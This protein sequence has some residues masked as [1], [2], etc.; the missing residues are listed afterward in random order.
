M[1]GVRPSLA[2]N[3]NLYSSSPDNAIRVV[4]SG[5]Q[6]PAKGELGYM[7]AFRY[8]LNDEQIAALL[9]Y[10]RQDFAKQKPWPDVQQR[11]A[12]LRAETAPSPQPSPTGRGS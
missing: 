10:L 2:L 3:S 12:E 9:N 1:Q 4:L 6:H 5:I 8:N 7:P 11:V